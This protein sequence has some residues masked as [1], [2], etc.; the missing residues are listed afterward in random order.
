MF[1]K[2]HCRIISF[3]H[4]KFVRFLDKRRTVKYLWFN[5]KKRTNN[6]IRWCWLFLKC[7]FIFLSPQIYQ[8][9]NCK[10]NFNH[11]LHLNITIHVKTFLVPFKTQKVHQNYVSEFFAQNKKTQ[12]KTYAILHYIFL[13][14]SLS[15]CL[16]VFCCKCNNF[17]Q[18][19]SNRNSIKN[20]IK[21]IFQHFLGV[22]EFS[23]FNYRSLLKNLLVCE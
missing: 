15:C 7:Y 13:M 3:G 20:A 12:H 16:I 21:K 17:Q 22:F 5:C 8:N 9:F 19:N 10:S 23:L 14:F 6:P 4:W 1:H 2:W 18:F 11:K